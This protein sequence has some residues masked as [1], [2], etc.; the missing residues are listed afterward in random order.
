MTD[1][2][3]GDASSETNVVVDHLLVENG[4]VTLTADIGKDEKTLAAEFSK[5]EIKGI[6]R[7]GNNTMEQVMQ[8]ILEPILKKAAREAAK[9]GLLDVAKDKLQDLI[10]G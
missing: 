6:G 9:E 10:D 2:L 4:S 5:I 8:Q 1:K 3:G 7:D